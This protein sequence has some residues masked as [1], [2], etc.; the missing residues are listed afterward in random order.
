[1]VKVPDGV[2]GRKLRQDD[3]TPA[4]LSRRIRRLVRYGWPQGDPEGRYDTRRTAVLAVLT[5]CAGGHYTKA[6]ALGL[7]TD[8]DNGIGQWLRVDSLGRPRKAKAAERGFDAL[9]RDACQYVR[10]HPT[11]R[12]RSECIVA[13]TAIQDAVANWTPIGRAERTDHLVLEVHVE[14]AMRTGKLLHGAS[15]RSVAEQVGIAD[16]TVTDSHRRLERSGWL[17]VRGRNQYGTKQWELR[18][19][20]ERNQTAQSHLLFE[21]GEEDCAIGFHPEPGHDMWRTL[22][23]TAMAYYHAPFWTKP[24]PTGNFA[25]AFGVGQRAALKQLTKLEEVLLAQRTPHGW[26]RIV[27]DLDLL[28]FVAGMEGAA[29]IQRL[30]HTLNRQ[31]YAQMVSTRGLSRRVHM[32]TTTAEDRPPWAWFDDPETGERHLVHNRPFFTDPARVMQRRRTI[33]RLR[34][35]WLFRTELG[36]VIERDRECA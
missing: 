17:A 32:T 10:M 13:V 25:A 28:A 30:R 31:G 16:R 9:W 23:K 33:R 3:I 7:F 5:A 6:E 24:L 15:V 20:K 12:G 18:L 27:W 4:P 35:I 36:A 19:P 8:P 1:M 14:I 21:V 26:R 34:I 2:V 11:M 29:R 22:G